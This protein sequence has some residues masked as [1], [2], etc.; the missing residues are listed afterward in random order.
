M[1][2]YLGN[3]TKYASFCILENKTIDI[4][5]SSHSYRQAYLH[6]WTDL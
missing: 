1:L 3:L 6:S 5:D 2:A 4:D